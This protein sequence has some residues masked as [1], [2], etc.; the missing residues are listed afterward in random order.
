M[1]TCTFR[2]FIVIISSVSEELNSVETAL[3]AKRKAEVC[4]VSEELNSVETIGMSFQK[5]IRNGVSEELNSVETY[6]KQK[7]I[8]HI[9]SFQKNLIVW[10]RI[11]S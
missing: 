7:D 1:E 11:K 4:N 6:W 3:S 10:K 8:R 5:Y 2:R 9:G